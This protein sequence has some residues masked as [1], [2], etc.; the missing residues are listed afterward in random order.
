MKRM[1]GVFRVTT[2]ALASVLLSGTVAAAATQSARS[3]AS[4]AATRRD[5]D[6]ARIVGYSMTR[7]GASAFLETLTDTIGGRITG[8]PES[9]AT[10][11][12]LLK[13]LK[14]AGF[15]NAHFE[16]YEFASTWQHGPAKGEVIS[17][18]RR[19]LMIGSYGWVPGTPGAIEVPVVDFGAPGENH[20][21]TAAQVRGAAVLVDLRSNA[22]SSAYVG[23]RFTTSQQMAQAGAAAMFI[24]SDKPDRMLYMSAYGNYPRAPLPILSI[25]SD[26]AALL[27][28]L[29]VKGPVKLRLDVQ[30]TFGGPVRERNVV[31]DLKGSDP[32]GI[33][34]LGAHFDS[35]DPA[36]GALDNGEGT[37]VQLEVARV[38]QALQIRPKH[39][40]RFAFFSGEEQGLN[41]SAAYVEQHK[42][43]LDK[44]WAMFDVHG[45]MVDV[46]GR[47]SSYKGFSIQGR[48]DLQAATKRLL[49]PLAGLGADKVSLHADFDGDN[50]SFMVVGVPTYTELA[51]PGDHT[52]T[53]HTIIDSFERIDPAILGQQTAIMAVTAYSFANAD[54]APG[55]R[56]TPAEVQALLK[57]TDLEPLYE[58]EHGPFKVTPTW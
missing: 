47:A 6:I 45:A 58:M 5:E 13:T 39:T 38:L 31:A 17:P 27:R 15:E 19:A 20:V 16:E 2:G 10:A 12:L 22:S 4:P 49:K 32:S 8:S 40:I 24:I 46:Q 25:A 54:E 37:A 3:N 43:E 14:D 11:E 44:T 21:P 1:C 56:A 35:W 51:E 7:G 18:V 41:G 53:Q 36:Q 30:N 26:D 28:R 55:R 29:L 50:E 9:R 23:T 33:V 57:R 42:G 34:L 48:P 52:A